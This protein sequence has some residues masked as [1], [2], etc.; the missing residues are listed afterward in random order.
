MII[1]LST[2]YKT[3]DQIA[4]RNRLRSESSK[5]IED[6]MLLL[7]E[8]KNYVDLDKSHAHA[9]FLFPL[10]SNTRSGYTRESMEHLVWILNSIHTAIIQNKVDLTNGILSVSKGTGKFKIDNQD[11]K[12]P[13]MYPYDDVIKSLSNLLVQ[14]SNRIQSGEIIHLNLNKTRGLVLVKK[15][16]YSYRLIGKRYDLMN[17]LA[18]GNFY[19]TAA[20]TDLLTDGDTEYGVPHAVRE[21][22]KACKENLHLIDDVVIS[23]WGDGYGIDWEKYSIN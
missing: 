3:I 1:A 10:E 22:R 4:V 13:S 5:N 20:L 8:C 21:I 7:K 16:E 6:T 12:L 11:L 2:K 14:R 15:P 17:I 23:R 18:R 19:R 9:T